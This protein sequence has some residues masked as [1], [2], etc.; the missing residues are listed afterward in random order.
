MSR[1]LLAVLLAA[2]VTLAGCGSE[3]GVGETASAALVPQVQDVR[4]SAEMRNRDEALAKLSALRQTVAGLR[5][6][7]DLTEQARRVFSMRP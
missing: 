5:A 2:G 3:Q 7:G 6:S 1:Q 4:A